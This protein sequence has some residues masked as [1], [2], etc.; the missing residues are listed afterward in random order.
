MGGATSSVC[1]RYQAKQVKEEHRDLYRSRSPVTELGVSAMGNRK[2]GAVP[3]RHVSFPMG[4]EQNSTSSQLI[5]DV[6]LS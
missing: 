6:I 1:F 2:S 5:W 3:N 4:V